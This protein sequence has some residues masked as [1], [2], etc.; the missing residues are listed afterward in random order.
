MIHLEETALSS[1]ADPLVYEG[2]VPVI[3]ID[4]AFSADPEDRKLVGS[5]IDQAC[6]TSGFFVIVGHRIDPALVQRMHELTLTFFHAPSASKQQYAVPM[7]EAVS[8]GLFCRSSYVAAAEGVAT[9]PDLCE[10]FTINQLGEA[11]VAER[12]D[13]GDAFSHWSRANRWPS[14]PIDFRQ[15]WTAYYT[16]MS[17]LA[18][19]LMRMCALGL[20]LPEKFFDPFID[21]H[22]SNLT[23]N[24]YPPL[25]SDPLPNQ[26]RKGPH[27]D[28]G[29]LTVL[30]QDGTGGLQVL[31]KDGEWVDV[32]VIAGSFVV[33]LG[34]LMAI[35]TNDKWVSTKHRVLA[36]PLP[37]REAERLSIAFFHQPNWSSLIECLPSCASTDSPPRHRPVTSGAY[38]RS[39]MEL[40]KGSGG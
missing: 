23:A 35:W 38:L 29:T 8:R 12:A 36:P 1:A 39:K 7:G 28:W 27:S 2:Y 16:A 9:A 21:V 37:A 30:Y 10:L 32:P 14:E 20:E 40:F 18:E 13:L 34:D 3:D 31:D 25:R 24:W 5:A 4:K 19:Q 6:S 33:N 26:Y 11:G 15:C 17:E 22:I